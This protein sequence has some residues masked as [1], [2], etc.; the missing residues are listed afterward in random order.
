ML[1]DTG[2]Q[3]LNSLP[4]YRE[5]D[6]FSL[7]MKLRAE[8]YDPQLIS[9]ALTQARL[10]QKATAK[11][12][13][14]ASHLIFTADG[15]E[16]ATRKEVATIHAKHFIDAHCSHIL[17]FG[18][19]IGADSFSFASHGLA[20]TSI[21]IDD[22]A[23]AA[24][25]FNLSLYSSATVIHD[26]ANNVDLAAT[27]ADAIWIDPARRRNGKRIKDPE[28]WYPS[29]SHTLELAT[30]FNAAGIKVAPGIDYS[31]LPRHCHVQWISVN[32][33]LVEAVIWL[34]NA[35]PRPG[36]SALIIKNGIEH[37]F[38]SGYEDP[39]I[40]SIELEPREL[41]TFIFEP[42]PAVIRSG[43]ISALA[44]KYGLAPVSNR[45]AYMTGDCPID[46]PEISCFKVETVIDL[47]PKALRKELNSRGIGRVEI[48]KRGT[49]VVPEELRKKLKLNPK[50]P[51]SA[52]I[53]ATPLLGK[54]RA[55]LAHR[56]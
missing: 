16:Q 41:G 18:C 5:Q 44:K 40:P 39:R 25:S 52:T 31:L 28:Q 51:G 24:A 11:F 21:E 47:N 12:G 33:D 42:D 46:A 1:T 56:Q 4:S 45:I 26:D 23:A 17:D 15:I 10:R 34:G 6:V 38:D 8:G 27:G 55:V 2:A 13:D 53:I 20:V 49:D 43:S 29:F 19:G 36:R 37:Q 35:S 48:K 30:Q 50:H 22:D 32:G 9:E 54:H 3:L 14:D 7:S